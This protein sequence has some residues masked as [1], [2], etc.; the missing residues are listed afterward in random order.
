MLSRNLR[1]LFL[2]LTVLTL[3]AGCVGQPDD[4]ED[5]IDITDPTGGDGKPGLVFDFTATWCVNCPRM[6]GALEDAARERP[7][8]IFPVS[9]HFQDAFTVEACGEIISHFDIEAYPS[10]VVNLD[11]ASLMT[12][13]SK[14]LLLA[15]LD[16][17]AR[18]R[19]AACSLVGTVS[20]NE[21]TVTVTA[22]YLI[23][24][25][26]HSLFM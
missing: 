1:H 4:G 14:D 22:A 10:A 9:I 23:V 3:A 8:K 11:P 20:G 7:G 2:L 18:D 6:A 13:T 12:A 24:L 15:R 26:R 25:I 21:L 16:A 5:D 17:T 19:K